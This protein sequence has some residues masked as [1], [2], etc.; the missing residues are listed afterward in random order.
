MAPRISF[1]EYQ[2]M[3]PFC[4]TLLFVILAAAV[5]AAIVIGAHSAAGLAQHLARLE[6][7]TPQPLVKT[8]ATPRIVL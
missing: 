1:R 7:A 3:R 2:T 5:A 6:K 4:Q 8:P